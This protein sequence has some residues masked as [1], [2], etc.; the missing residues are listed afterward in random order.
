MFDISSAIKTVCIF[1]A[2]D[3]TARRENN[4]K[5]EE[6]YFVSHKHKHRSQHS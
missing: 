2:S 4:N 1:F 6:K 3:A 5:N